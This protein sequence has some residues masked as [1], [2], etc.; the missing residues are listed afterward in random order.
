MI[1]FPSLLPATLSRQRVAMSAAA[2]AP[3]EKQCFLPRSNSI[4]RL[5]RSLQ[6]RILPSAASRKPFSPHEKGQQVPVPSVFAT[7]CSALAVPALAP[8]LERD[9][10]DRSP[11]RPYL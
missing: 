5:P 2:S 3:R 10:V 4:S 6:C 11:S 7:R 8:H 9:L 1:P